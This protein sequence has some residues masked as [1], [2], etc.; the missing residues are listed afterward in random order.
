METFTFA[1]RVTI[2]KIQSWRKWRK[3][4]AGGQVAHFQNRKDKPLIPMDPLVT[5]NRF[6]IVHGANLLLPIMLLMRVQGRETSSLILVVK[7]VPEDGAR[8]G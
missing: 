5:V 4:R 8:L 6:I 1:N 3:F 7:K 2:E